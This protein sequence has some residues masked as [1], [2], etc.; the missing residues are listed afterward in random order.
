[1]RSEAELDDLHE[2]TVARFPGG[3]TPKQFALV[4]LESADEDGR[5]YPH[6]IA[7]FFVKQSILYRMA[8][9]DLIDNRARHDAP[10]EWFITDKGRA[11]I[12]QEVSAQ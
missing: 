11:F 8:M 4:T 1:M 9:D 5:V 10:C 2:K 6:S 12:R 3:L 7:D